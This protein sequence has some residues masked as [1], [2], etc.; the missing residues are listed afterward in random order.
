MPSPS[1]P[2][3]LKIPPS[4][5]TVSVRI[6][7]S[8]ARIKLPTSLF[9]SPHIHGHDHLLAPSYAFLI[10]H[11]SG[12][13]LLLDNGVRKDW[14]N[15]SPKIRKLIEESGWEVSVEKNVVDILRDGGIQ[16]ESIECIAWSHYHWD[17]IGSPHLF[18]ASTSLI[19]GPGFKATYLPGYP[20][21]PTSPI[22]ES[23]YTGRHIA[24]ISFT[25]STPIG[26]LR[27]H[28]YFSDG[29]F[30]LLE[31]GGHAVGHMC[32]FARVTSA[33]P[34]STQMPGGLEGNNGEREQKDGFIF[35]AADTAHHPA[36]FRPT[37]YTP[38]PPQISPSP[39]TPTRPS[40]TLPTSV[41]KSIHRLPAHYATAPFYTLKIRADG[42]SVADNPLLAK[43]TLKK[44]EVF[45]AQDSVFVV[46]AHDAS[47]LDV[48]DFFPRYADAWVRKGWKVRGRWGFLRDFEVAV[49]GGG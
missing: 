37:P 8:T 12:R 28:D 19:V 45:D 23:D 36:E 27:A 21:S 40:S 26:G 24:E 16:P 10:E 9:V 4:T 1:S 30:Y 20:S 35:M 34:T 29:S 7:D 48:I 3:P 11:P 2:P 25:T 41:F 43:E 47:L 6:I 15:Y 32:G 49:E 33:P 31:A 14:Q 46:M 13:K 39:L 42:S 5:S 38:L 44:V 22:Q 18:P 17:H